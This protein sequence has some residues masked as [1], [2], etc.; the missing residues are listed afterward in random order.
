MNTFEFLPN[1]ILLECFCYFTALDLF[2]SFD[3]LNQRFST[4]IR[5]ISLDFNFENVSMTKMKQFCDEFEQNP[6]LKQN[7]H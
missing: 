1:E 3:H 4:L 6:S 2:H 5:S 7:V